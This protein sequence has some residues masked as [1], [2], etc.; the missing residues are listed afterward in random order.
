MNKQFLLH[1]NEALNN[2]LGYQNMQIIQRNDMLNFS[3][4]CVLL[5]AFVSL[6]AKTKQIVDFGT[7]NGPIP[8][9][10]ST[11]TKA[12]ITGIDIQSEAVDLAKRNI[13][14]NNLTEQV[15][16]I[17]QDITNIE[18]IFASQSVDVVVSNPPFFKITE[19][20]QLNENEFLQIARHEVKIDLSQLITKASYIL[21]N[22]GY[23]AMVHRPDRLIE[24]INLLQANKLEPKRIQ[25]IYPKKETDANMLLIE[26]R[27]NGNTG[28]KIMEPI[29][30]HEENG[31]YTEPILKLFK[32]M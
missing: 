28:L 22:N 3:L 2:L 16:I 27:K 1:K 25:L 32:R 21:N 24:I 9:F 31:D 29:I 14:L 4:D 15:E 10:L 5:S 13:E 6:P 20:K 18:Q 11:R 19:D 7:G 8:L 17:E 12:K 30:V 23:F 26:A